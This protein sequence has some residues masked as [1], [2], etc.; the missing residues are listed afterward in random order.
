[1]AYGSYKNL[2]KR[3]ESYKELSKKAFAIL[4]DPEYNGYQCGLVLI[5][6]E[7]FNKTFN[8]S[9]INSYNQQIANELQ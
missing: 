6:Y 7:L 4:N 2:E 3:S 1:M 9:G 8:G 5:V